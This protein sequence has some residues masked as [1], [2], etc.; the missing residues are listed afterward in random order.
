MC[1]QTSLLMAGSTAI[2][3]RTT[4]AKETSEDVSVEEFVVKSDTDEMTSF[5]L[6]DVTGALNNKK[7]KKGLRTMNMDRPVARLC[8]ACSFIAILFNSQ[9]NKEYSI[10]VVKQTSVSINWPIRILHKSIPSIVHIRD[11]II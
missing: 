4:D 7:C 8:H 10:Y 9:E 2:L 3:L 11:S 5:T 1:A 6:L